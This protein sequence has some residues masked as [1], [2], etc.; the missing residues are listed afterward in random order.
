MKVDVVAKAAKASLAP[1]QLK[2]FVDQILS[3]MDELVGADR[4]DDAM[5]L[6]PVALEARSPA[7]RRCAVEA[8]QPA[9]EGGRGGPQELRRAPTPC[10]TAGRQPDDAEANYRVGRYRAAVKG[11]WKKA[12]PMLAKGSD[13]AWKKLAEQE[14]ASPA[15]AREQLALANGWWEL[16]D[17]AA[18]TEKRQPESER[19]RAPGIARS[20]RTPW[21][22]WTRCASR[23]GWPTSTSRSP[24]TSF[25]AAPRAGRAP[26]SS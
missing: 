13:A 3:L 25:P 2:V 20:S 14:L 22:A 4:F 18:D 6:A 7:A 1:P 10:G 8:G 19:T 24:T 12:L 23:I 9:Q 15:E 17:S 11:D 5:A 26:I 16:A 21:W